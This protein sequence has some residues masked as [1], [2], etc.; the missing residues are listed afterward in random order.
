MLAWYREV[1]RMKS[2]TFLF[3]MGAIATAA[4]RDVNVIPFTTS[5][6]VIEATTSGGSR[7]LAG[8]EMAV[9]LTS[10]GSKAERASIFVGFDVPTGFFYWQYGTAQGLI[11]EI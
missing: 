6:H 4:I 11:P 9:E 7:L 2:L 3:S 1:C 5:D 8:R 10:P